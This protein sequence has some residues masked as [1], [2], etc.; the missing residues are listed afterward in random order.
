MIDATGRARECPAG[1][2]PD[3]HIEMFFGGRRPARPR[4]PGTTAAAFGGTTTLIDFC[5]RGARDAAAEALGAYHEKL[6][7]ARW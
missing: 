2:T 6:S 1:S 5:N 7:G 4:P 3:T